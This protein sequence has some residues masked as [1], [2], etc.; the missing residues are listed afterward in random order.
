MVAIDDG[1]LDY[2]S[3]LLE[4]RVIAKRNSTLTIEIFK[5][6]IVAF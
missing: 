1:I 6:N 5:R 4:N 3:D 2:V